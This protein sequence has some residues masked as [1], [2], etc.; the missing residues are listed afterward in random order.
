MDSWYHDCESRTSRTSDVPIFAEEL[1]PG[2]ITS[3]EVGDSYMDDYGNETGK[4]FNDGSRN[5]GLLKMVIE[6]WSGWPKVCRT[7]RSSAT[8]SAVNC[9]RI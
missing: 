1:P 4:Y 6:T 3:F 7:I 8:L 9:L 5:L 2:T